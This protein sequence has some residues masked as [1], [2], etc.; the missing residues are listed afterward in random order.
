MIAY[1]LVALLTLLLNRVLPSN[2]QKNFIW[3]LIISFIPLF[4]YGAIRVDYGNDY[5]AY[6]YFFDIYHGIGAFVGDSD[7][8]AEVGYQYLCY[9]MPSY[10]SILVLSSF[11]LSASYIYFIYKNVEPQ[12]AWLVI[13][14]IFLMPDKNVFGS[15]VGI[16][17]GLVV[18]SFLLTYTFI[19][20][21]KFYIILPIAFL[22]SLIHTSAL[23]YIPLAYLIARD[24]PITQKEVYIW[25][26]SV[27]VIMLLST[28]S[29]VLAMM[30]VISVV[31]G[32]YEETLADMND[33]SR[34]LLNYGANLVMMVSFL[35]FAFKQNYSL[36]P[37]QKSI[38]RMGA[39][40]C[41][42]GCLGVISGRMTYFF[43]L[44]YVVSVVLMFSHLEYKPQIRRLLLVFVIMIACYATFYV[45]MGSPWWSHAVYH[46][47]LGD[48]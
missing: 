32:R 42:S 2:T 47:L 12:Y 26:G 10:R 44:F 18:S 36:T 14:L 30:P 29:I 16:R 15:L 21:R 5:S 25:I 17:N 22:L 8:H 33:T 19:Q 31:A 4:I 7:A 38:F 9:I 20:E 48:M 39:L 3:N 28:S 41:F 46:S 45:W 27:I 43:A 11:L 6:E 34:G 37:S 35:W 23:T 24:S 40:Y 1:W 13:L